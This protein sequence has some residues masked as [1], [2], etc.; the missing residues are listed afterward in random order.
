MTLRLSPADA[1]WFY[2]ENSANPMMISAIL[3]F[4]RRLDVDRL[5]E[6]F[7]ERILAR[8]PVFTQC[9]VPP[10]NP[11]AMPRWEDDPEFDLDRHVEVSELPDPGEQEQLESIVSEQRST[12]LA[13]DHPLWKVHV[14]NNYRGVASAMHVRIHHSV[15]DGLA[16]MAL[17]LSLA[18]EFEPGAV[19][20]AEDHHLGFGDI[21]HRAE[22]AV[23]EAS[24]MALRPVELTR[25]VRRTADAARW[26]GK[27]LTPIIAD[28]TVLIGRPQG[29]KRAVWDPA[30]LPLDGVK[31]AGKRYGAT[32]N[33]VLLSLMTGALHRY[34]SDYESVVDDAVMV[35]PVNLRIPG[36]PLPRHLGNRIGLLP[37]E[38]PVGI[39]DAEERLRVIQDRIGAVKDSPAP[40]VSR[41]VLASTALLSPAVERGV[42]RLNQIRGTGVV[43]NVPGPQFPLHVGGALIEGVVGWGGMTAHL[44]LS[45]AFVSLNGRIF[46]GFVTDEAI[47]PDPERILEYLQREWAEWRVAVAA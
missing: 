46:S 23:V 25:T 22:Q 38:L 44:N 19:P 41:L 24:R 2:G 21:L 7:E 10:L 1:V 47:T 15:G 20:L 14:F 36:E 30:G 37:I 13:R 12:P 31:R 27:L 42:H 40:W 6:R 34:L 43:T 33:D 9:I 3:W 5:R 35:V 32:I 45:A 8:H 28:R 29:D 17:M 4:D 39:R 16:L 11:F 26:A 18:D